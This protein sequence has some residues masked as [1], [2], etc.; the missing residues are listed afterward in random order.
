MMI[1]V[2]TAVPEPKRP[3]LELAP[4]GFAVID[5]DTGKT[6]TLEDLAARLPWKDNLLMPHEPRMPAHS[7]VVINTLTDEERRIAHMIEFIVD[8]HPAGYRAYFRGYKSAGRYLE[9]GS[10]PESFRYW[11]SRWP[12]TWFLNRCRLDACE[13][14]RRID[15]GAKAIDP[16]P[17]SEPWYPPNH[18]G[19]WRKRS[20]QWIFEPSKPPYQR[21]LFE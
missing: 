16:W 12:Q 20:G 9:L 2:V 8:R 3:P 7:Y 5:C 18:Y 14:P 13:A 21:K 19:T 15:Q 17:A 1:G 6:H 10:G 4:A 11:R